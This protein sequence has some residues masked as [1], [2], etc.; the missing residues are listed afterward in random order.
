MTD[1]TVRGDLP[2]PATREGEVPF[3]QSTSPPPTIQSVQQLDRSVKARREIDVP[4]VNWWLYVLLVAPVTLWIYSVYLFFKRIT[5]VDGFIEREEA[6]YESV[7]AFTERYAEERGQLDS[8]H[9][10]IGDARDNL[11]HAFLDPVKPIRAGL[12]LV[13]TV[14]TLGLYGFYVQYRLNKVWYDLQVVEQEFD[15]ALS[16]V[17]Q[18]VGLAKY[19]IS[20]RLDPSK[21]RS[22]GLYLLLSIVTLGV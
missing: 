8:V 5:R 9:A 4:L 21:R 12:S 20:F 10:E 3:R 1:E 17:W 16:V 15:D 22:Y 13:L 6:Y 14:V 11:R 7:L 19:A 2:V 18:K